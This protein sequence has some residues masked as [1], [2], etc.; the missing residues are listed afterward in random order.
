MNR[1]ADAAAAV[2][3]LPARREGGRRDDRR[4]PRV[5]AARPAS[6][7]G[8]IVRQPRRLQRRRLG[9]RP[10]APR[11]S[12]RARDLRRRRRG[13]RGAGL[14]DRAPRQHQLR[15][16]D[17]ERRSTASTTT[18]SPTSRATY[19]EPVRRRP[20]TARTASRG[21][22]GRRSRRSSS[23]NGIRLDTNYYYWP[24][25]WVQDRPGYFTG[26][27]MPMRFADLDGSL[28]DVY[29]A[30]TQMT[31][32]S[33]IDVRHAHQHAARQRHR[34]ARLLRRRHHE[35]AHRHPPTTRGSRPSS[36]PRMAR[37]VPVV[38]ARQ[39]LTWLDGRNGSSFEDL[40]W[41]AGTLTFSIGVGAPAPTAS[42][43]CCRRD[44]RKRRPPVAEPRRRT[45]HRH[46]ADDQGHRVRGLRRDRR[47][48]T[49]TYD[50]DTTPPTITSV[51]A[52]PDGR[53][54][55]NGHLDD[56]RAGDLG[57]TT[58][59]R[60]ARSTLNVDRSRRSSTS[61][62]VRAHRARPE[63]HV[64]LPGLVHGRREQHSDVA[65]P[66]GRA[67]HLHDADRRRDRHDRGRLRRRHDRSDHLRGR[68][69][70]RR[71]HPR[72]DGRRRVRRHQPA[73]PA[74]RA[75]PGPAGRR[76]DRRR[77]PA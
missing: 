36:T 31:D 60:P 20:P 18:S 9:V 24:A 75:R 38:S 63:H 45:R 16:L 8:T 4:R 49:A 33:G 47:R 76:R 15:G 37:G 51:A 12:T 21:A 46:T 62:T 26:S 58:A 50:V 19:P 64:P 70:G 41:N 1:D 11:T 66:A 67:G 7:T 3:V 57:S 28:I 68:D 48:Y 34:R 43:R 72:A 52:V 2:L 59:R 71:G 39:M 69:V 17:A 74:G 23:T 44:G 10:A 13:V 40:A 29:Q 5:A 77:R 65:G 30:A 25:A 56:R 54:H 27:G 14:R 6:S 22:T 73:R 35:H 61:H 42:R 32:E 53:R 55:R